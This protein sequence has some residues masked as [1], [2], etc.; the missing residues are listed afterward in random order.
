MLAAL[1]GAATLSACIFVRSPAVDCQAISAEDCR[2]AV[3]MARPLV[4]SFWENANRVSVHAGS[5]SQGMRCPPA[6]ATDPG[7]V[8]VELIS[9]DPEAR[10]VV[11]DRR[12]AEWTAKCVV[13]VV[14]E[15]GAHTAACVG[16]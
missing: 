5:C 3:E 12:H 13:L 7:H 16:S 1:S 10:F 14:S 2:R 9:N 11:I 15:S 4:S 8:T 6:V